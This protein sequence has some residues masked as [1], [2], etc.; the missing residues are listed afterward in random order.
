MQTVS[1]QHMYVW[2]L[3]HILYTVVKYELVEFILNFFYSI[4]CVIMASTQYVI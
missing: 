4:S 1:I 3:H 2:E